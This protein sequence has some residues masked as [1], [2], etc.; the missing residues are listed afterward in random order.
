MKYYLLIDIG[1]SAVKALSGDSVVG[2][3]VGANA[4][5]TQFIGAAGAAVSGGSSF[6]GTVAVLVNNN[7]VI[8]DAS[9]ATLTSGEQFGDPFPMCLY[10]RSFMRRENSASSRG[11]AAVE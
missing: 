5:E 2:I 10:P 8:A 6:N 9:R 1:G 7:T 3:Y 4:K 11:S